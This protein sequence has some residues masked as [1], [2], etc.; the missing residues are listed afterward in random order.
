MALSML[1]HTEEAWEAKIC[2]ARRGWWRMLQRSQR[3]TRDQ[4]AIRKRCERDPRYFFRHFIWSQDPRRS[5]LGLSVRTPFV[6]Y[7]EQEIM[8][9]ALVNGYPLAMDKSRD[10]G[11][12]Y[13]ACAAALYCWLFRPGSIWGLSSKTG[14][15]AADGSINSLL[16]K[17]M[18]MLR[19]LPRWMQPRRKPKYRTRPNGWLLNRDN[20]AE[21]LARKTTPDAWHSSRCTAIIFDEIARTPY[22]GRMVNGAQGTTNQTVLITTPAGA[23]GWWYKLIHGD[24]DET[25]QPLDVDAVLAGK[26]PKPGYHK[27]QLH[28][29]MDPRYDD[30]EWLIN[31]EIS[32]RAATEGQI[33]PEFSRH[34]HVMSKEDWE[35]FLAEDLPRARIYEGWD[36][37]HYTSVIWAAHLPEYDQLIVLDYISWHHR[38]A[39]QVAGDISDYRSPAAPLGW[40]TFENR[41]GRLPEVRV[42]DPAMHHIKALNMRTWIQDLG[43]LG[44]AVGTPPTVSGKTKELR[45]RVAAALKVIGDGT[46]EAPALLFSPLCVRKTD[47]DLP[48]LVDAMEQYRLR[49]RPGDNLP[50]PDKRDPASHPADALQYICASV[51]DDGIEP[52]LYRKEDGA[53]VRAD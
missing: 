41:A 47:A 46:E 29:R 13:V 45:N 22:P 16:G 12:S 21:I 2:G 23:H 36:V 52:G 53:F 42:G 28:W 17:V 1:T 25:I 15:E 3:R 49:L 14:S 20:D 4:A 19:H 37:G 34:L 10:T 5:T 43:E 35:Y 48:T 18:Y 44:I 11:A 38:S 27:Y 32:Y 33:W 6:P 26:P 40:R 39:E 7:V 9:V 30:L 24:G 51:W 50:E 31:Y 8:F